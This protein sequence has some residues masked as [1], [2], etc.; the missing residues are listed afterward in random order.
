M[1]K[2]TIPAIKIHQ[3]L[4]D[5]KSLFTT[6]IKVSQLVDER[7]FKVDYYEHKNKHA[8][9]GYQ[10]LPD[11]KH[12]QSIVRY[13]S[14]QSDNPTFPSPIVVSSRDHN[15]SFDDLMLKGFGNLTLSSDQPLYI[16]DGQ[17][18][19]EAWK[20]IATRKK[21][22]EKFEDFEVEIS[23]FS[24]LSF[25]EEVA[26]F[27][28]I[29]SNQKPVRTDF[30]QRLMLELHKDPET[31]KLIPAEKRWQHFAVNL[32][33][34]IHE[35]EQSA[36]YGK[37][38]LPNKQK[39]TQTLVTQ[40]TFISSLKPLFK[41][42]SKLIDQDNPHEEYFYQATEAINTFWNTVADV[43]PEGTRMNPEN[44][45]LMSAVGV[46][47]LHLFLKDIS[48]EISLDKLPE[49]I[50]TVVKDRLHRA[51]EGDFSTEFWR[52]REKAD[53]RVNDKGYAGSYAYQDGYNRLASFLILGRLM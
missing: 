32:F 25:T 26:Q 44:F 51:K 40:N 10:R 5:D 11:E 24:G 52:K 7:Y 27:V 15:V 21:S 38:L 2:L 17:H 48:Q 16:I 4:E 13:I 1:D 18:R 53:Y 35:D 6:K 37:V 8:T 47:A 45:L 34:T 46:H 12:V 19:Y 50:N 33:D 42:R 3:S 49:H 43:Y 39:T 22:F 14:N 9:S 28:L 30:A 31:R 29:N 36:W 41:G 20:K 23:L